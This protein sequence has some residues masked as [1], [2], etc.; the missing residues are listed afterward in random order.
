MTL[1]P[2]LSRM[3]LCLWC[4]H[5]IRCHPWQSSTSG[6]EDKLQLHHTVRTSPHSVFS[7]SR[8]ISCFYTLLCKCMVSSLCYSCPERNAQD[9]KNMYCSCVSF[10]LSE[11][12]TAVCVRFLYHVLWLPFSSLFAKWNVLFTLPLCVLKPLAETAVTVPLDPSHM[13]QDVH[14]HSKPWS[15]HVSVFI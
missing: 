5:T 4:H 7:F 8:W 15:D 1:A 10:F 6:C 2:C 13:A 12:Y 14:V 3:L 11:T 9:L